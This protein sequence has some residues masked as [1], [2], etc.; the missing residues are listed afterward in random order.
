MDMTP[1]NRT[2]LITGASRGI[3]RAI[4]LALGNRQCNIIVNYFTSADAAAETVA[5][6]EKAGGR[7]IA[8]QADVGRSEDRA[9]LVAETIKAF[10]AIDV[11]INN[12]GIPP[13]RRDD[14]LDAT[15]DI[16]DRV[17]DTNLKGP[18]FLTQLVARRM[19]EANVARLAAGGPTLPQPLPKREGSRSDS[20]SASSGTRN[21]EPGTRNPRL[22]ININSL[23]AYA[24]SEHRSQYCIAKAGMT[25]MTQLF[26]ARLAR[27]GI[28][29]FEIRPGVIDTDMARNAKAKYDKLI[30]EDDLLPM[31]RWGTGEDVARAVLAIIDGAFPYSTGAV[32]DVDGGYHIRRL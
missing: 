4:A 10:G 14:L 16:Y 17:M 30:Y 21:P 7:A 24:A 19:V 6:V 8:V 11:L 13:A 2:V 1:L 27:E 15:E 29:V 9:R 12:A 32:F 23:S 20:P 22:I 31:A 18:F 28:Q 26:A 3:G 5:L 25:M